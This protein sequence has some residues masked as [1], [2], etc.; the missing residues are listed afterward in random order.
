MSIDKNRPS[1][2][3]GPISDILN[4]LDSFFQDAFR[5]LQSPRFIPTNQY[6]TD[7]E[8]IIEA[9][10]PGV[11][12]EQL[13]LDIYRNYIRI[14]L[15]AEEILEQKDDKNKVIRHN[16][17]YE[18][19]ERVVQLPFVVDESEVKAELKDG[20]LTIRIPNKRKRIQID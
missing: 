11:N 8:Y 13:S 15:R 2:P 3:E 7:N 5:H 19:A 12:K 1:L 20:L 14:S 10:L 4:S 17:R 16:S 6:E 9:E 18:R